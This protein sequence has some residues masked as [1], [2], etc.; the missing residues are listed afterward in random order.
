M[1]S[2][3]SSRTSSADLELPPGPSYPTPFHYFRELRKDPLAYYRSLVEEYGAIACVK[4]WPRRQ[5]VTS[6]PHQHRHVLIDQIDRY[7]KGI[8]FARRK[9]IGGEGLFFSEGEL[10]KRQRRSMMPSFRKSALVELVPHMTDG[11]VA[12][13]G[14][15]EK[16]VG[17][18][19]FNIAPEMAKLAMDIAC[20]AFFGCDILDRA[21]SL[22]EALWASSQYTGHVSTNPLAPPIWFP[23]KLNRQARRALQTM[24]GAIDEL[25]AE[26]RERAGEDNVLAR[27]NAFVEDGQMS[28]RQLRY[29]MWTLLNAGHETT[30]TTLAFAFSLL[31]ENPTARERVEEEADALHGRPPS[32]ADLESLAHTN[33]V[34]RETLRLFPP[35]WGT[36]RECIEDDVIDGYRIPAGSIM[37]LL[38]FVT[39]KDPEFWEDPERFDPDRFLPERSADRHEEAWCPFGLGGRR[40]IGEDFAMMEA[41]IALAAVAQRLELRLAPGAKVEGQVYGI[42]PMRPAA[43]LPMTVHRRGERAGDAP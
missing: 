13:L 8:T 21:Q 25:I 35:A 12:F 4:M 41:T 6:L 14:R 32:Y 19:A 40:C 22:H 23:T 5:I 16:R 36:G 34:V 26:N 18:P 1:P 38:L 39:Q 10:W 20:R 33:R 24:Y 27:L 29:E 30:A 3:P 15:M 11:A 7:P 42:G 2:D 9:D 31:S 43:G 17:E 37:T 28:E